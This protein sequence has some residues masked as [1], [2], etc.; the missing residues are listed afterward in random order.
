MT[1]TLQTMPR[2]EMTEVEG[3]AKASRTSIAS[4]SFVEGAVVVESIVNEE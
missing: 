4:C 1:T 2:A 3:C